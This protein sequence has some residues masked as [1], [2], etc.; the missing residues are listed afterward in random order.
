MTYLVAASALVITQFHTLS[1][2]AH[3]TGRTTGMTEKQRPHGT[4]EDD[5]GG[6]RGLTM[7]TCTRA[8]LELY[9]YSIFFSFHLLNTDT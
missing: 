9:L 8:S 3:H 5:N 7:K 2:N 4:Q 6:T 1:I